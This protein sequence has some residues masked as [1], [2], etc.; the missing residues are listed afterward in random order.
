[1]KMNISVSSVSIWLLLQP[2]LLD[3]DNCEE[4]HLGDCPVHG[5][6]LSLDPSSG[7]DEASKIANASLCIFATQFIPHGV[8]FG[9]YEGK[10]VLKEDLI[11][12]EDINYMWEVL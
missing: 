7:H 10:R 9:P 2:L 6:L 3:C 11:K 12:V 4:I 1:M 5:P 8:R